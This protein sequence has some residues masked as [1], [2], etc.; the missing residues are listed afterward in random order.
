MEELYPTLLHSLIFTSVILQDFQAWS[1]SLN[2][3]HSNIISA[4]FLFAPIN[5]SY[6]GPEESKS[7]PDRHIKNVMF[8][9]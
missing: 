2:E 5:M 6:A 9:F 4:E 3:G 7:T 8:S 1:V